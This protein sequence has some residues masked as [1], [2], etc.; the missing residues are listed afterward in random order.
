VKGTLDPILEATRFGDNSGKHIVCV[1][2]KNLKLFNKPDHVGLGDVIQDAGI[3]L[4]GRRSKGK[5]PMS[6]NSRNGVDTPKA[7][8][9]QRCKVL[10]GFCRRDVHPCVT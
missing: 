4:H 8:W 1:N 2:R 10:A 7:C 6:W 3:V 5:G 9:A